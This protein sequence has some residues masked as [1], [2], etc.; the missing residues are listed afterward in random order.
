[1][2]IIP[3]VALMS[4]PLYQEYQ[5]WLLH[6]G[7]SDEFI[8]DKAVRRFLEIVEEGS[9]EIDATLKLEAHRLFVDQSTSPLPNRLR[10]V[11]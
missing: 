3:A 7:I 5:S 9:Y 8:V 4:E 10:V 2:L 1:M 11:A 6:H